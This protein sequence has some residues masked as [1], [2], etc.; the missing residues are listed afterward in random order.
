MSR[1]KNIRRENKEFFQPVVSANLKTIQ[2]TS[3]KLPFTK[4]T[5]VSVFSK[6]TAFEGPEKMIRLETTT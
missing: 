4:K 5:T 6:L 1:S 2:A 3:L